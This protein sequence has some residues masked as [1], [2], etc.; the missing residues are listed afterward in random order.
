LN[1]NSATYK[2]AIPFLYIFLL[3]SRICRYSVQT[4]QSWT[5]HTRDDQPCMTKVPCV[6]V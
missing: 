6:N 4:V 5:I 2:N 1:K 3:E